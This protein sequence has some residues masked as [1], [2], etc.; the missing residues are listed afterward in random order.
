MNGVILYGPPASGKDTITEELEAIDDRYKLYP[1]IKIGNGRVR[2]YRTSGPEQLKSLRDSKEVVWETR[3]YG[4]IYI[5][6]RPSLTTHLT[7]YSSILHLGEP[8]AIQAITA[9]T[10][11]V[12]WT[13]AYLW[14]PRPIAALRIAYRA[15]RDDEERLSVW[16]KTPAIENAS[17]TIDTSRVTPKQAAHEVHAHAK[18]TGSG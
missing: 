17:V 14:C 13:V 15:T 12:T 6:D 4:S 18:T 11:N 10:P 8:N 1:R 16:D 5:V 7:S 3:R 2:G 9:A